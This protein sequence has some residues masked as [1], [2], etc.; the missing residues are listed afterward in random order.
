MSLHHSFPVLYG[1]D[2]SGKTKVWRAAIYHNDD[3]SAYSLI[4][5]GQ[6]DGKLQT[7]RRDVTTGK[8]LGKKNETTPLQQCLSETER[9]WLDKKEK[10]NYT[11]EVTEEKNSDEHLT[12]LPML[13]QTLKKEKLVF[14]VYV[15]PKID[16]LRCLFYYRSGEW[17]AQ[18]RTGAY[19]STVDHIKETLSNVPKEIV[20]DGELY[21]DTIPFETLA[22][23]LKKKKISVSDLEKLRHVKY[24]C[25]DV[26]LPQ[27][28][29]ADFEERYTVLSKLPVLQVVT[30]KVQKMEE[31]QEKFGEYTSQGYEGIMVRTLSGKYSLNYRSKDLCKYKEFEESEY[32]IK[33]FTQGDGRDVGT[34]IWICVTEQGKEFHVR[35]R[36]T[37]EQRSEWYREGVKYVGKKLT[38]IYQNLS[39]QGIPRFPVGKAVREGF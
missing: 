25:Y 39:E 8:N 11:E 38:V 22:G 27:K 3:G 19:F 1:Q 6:L 26:Y 21:S 7:A 37:H 9:K 29:D 2:K 4:E 33:G 16:G 24:H 23:L 12:L 35:P 36:G 14:P 10:E 20:L 17:A 32:E 34:V 15:Q 30:E 18:S 13:A 28:K 31:F 5:Y